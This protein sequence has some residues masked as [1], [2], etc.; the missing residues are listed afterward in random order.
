M[1][2]VRPAAY[3]AYELRQY[4]DTETVD[5]ISTA[6]ER[7][8]CESTDEREFS[9][10]KAER[11][12][13]ILTKKRDFHLRRLESLRKALEESRQAAALRRKG[14]LLLAYAPGVRDGADSTRL[15]GQDI[16]LD[17]NLSPIENAQSYFKRYRSAQS[18]GRKIPD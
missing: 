11:L 3:A 8:H 13:V 15:D 6:I 7:R 16:R 18:A 1:K 12:Q 14:E 2:T 17:P 5:S 4:P 10:P 9:S